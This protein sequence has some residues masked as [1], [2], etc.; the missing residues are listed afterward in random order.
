[1]ESNK[2]IDNDTDNNFEI[3]KTGKFGLDK[4]TKI[5]KTTK[6]L[7]YILDK[8][9][10]PKI[11]D[12]LSLDVEGSEL[13]ILKNFPF[14]KYTFL[15]LTIERPPIE[16]EEILFKNGYVFVKHNTFALPGQSY[17]YRPV[18]GFHACNEFALQQLIIQ[19][20]AVN[21]SGG[22]DVVAAGIRDDHRNRRGIGHDVI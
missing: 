21:I 7:E 14:N 18:F 2:I 22:D 15:A 20:Q 5:K 8:F 1:M 13:R 11:I 3:R 9:N 6:T 12:Y 4:S 16:L 10:A 17:F 19:Q